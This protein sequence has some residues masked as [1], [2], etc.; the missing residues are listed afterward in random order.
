MHE[1]S[2]AT[3][4]SAI[5]TNTDNISTLQAGKVDKETGKSLVSDSEISRLA[6]LANYDD[7][8]VK[9]DIADIQGLIPTSASPSNQLA[10]KAYV[11]AMQSSSHRIRA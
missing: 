2:A 6:T 10:D 4:N 9:S 1:G 8:A 5:Q 11:S 7:T 3:M